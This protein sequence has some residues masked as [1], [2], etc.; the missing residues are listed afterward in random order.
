MQIGE[1]AERSGVSVQ[2][3]R[4][5]ERR[6]VIAL[7]ARLS[8]GYSDYPRDAVGDILLVK[9][10]QTLGF[11]LREIG[12]LM[13]RRHRSGR[14]GGKALRLHAAAKRREID[15][16]LRVLRQARRRL[17]ELVQCHCKEGCP[18]LR[19]ARRPRARLRRRA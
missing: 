10:G 1:L 12:E 17:D 6:G 16:N 4:Y 11:S 5:Y 9:W 3:V 19:R 13:Q 18:I 8:S 15:A 14:Q 2:A 7:P